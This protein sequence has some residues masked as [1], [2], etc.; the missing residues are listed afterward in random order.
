[1]GGPTCAQVCRQVN[2]GG[3]VGRQVG[4]E[5]GVERCGVCWWTLLNGRPCTAYNPCQVHRGDCTCCSAVCGVAHAALLAWWEL[6]LSAAGT[7]DPCP[8]LYQLKACIG[9]LNHEHVIYTTG[10]SLFRLGSILFAWPE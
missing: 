8:G 4:S 7:F 10:G 2:S 6:Q 1:M 3:W 9:L 5:L